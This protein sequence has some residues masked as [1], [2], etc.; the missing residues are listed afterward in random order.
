MQVLQFP[1]FLM[2]VTGFVLE[3]D[4]W[5]CFLQK[6]RFLRFFIGLQRVYIS[7]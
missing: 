7:K 4:F 2:T 1:A 3:V 5:E 6:I